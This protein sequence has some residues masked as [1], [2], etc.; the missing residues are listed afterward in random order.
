[1][2]TTVQSPQQNLHLGLL[3]HLTNQFKDQLITQYFS[4][5]GITIILGAI[6]GLGEVFNVFSN[7]GHRKQPKKQH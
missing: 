1:M 5:A 6:Y 2:K 3:F 4:G 7:V